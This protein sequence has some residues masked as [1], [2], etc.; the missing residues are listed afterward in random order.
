MFFKTLYSI[1]LGQEN[2]LAHMLFG[3]ISLM[4][5]LYFHSTWACTKGVSCLLIVI[6]HIVYG[7]VKDDIVKVSSSNVVLVSLSIW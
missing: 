2:Q 1:K 6:K 3:N 5:Y 4:F 7:F